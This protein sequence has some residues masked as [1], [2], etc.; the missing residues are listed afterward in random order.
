[1]IWTDA[2]KKV[3]AVA[4]DVTPEVYPKICSAKSAEYVIA[5]NAGQA[6][7]ANIQAGQALSFKLLMLS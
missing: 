6:D 4:H 2:N 3:V 1:M 5:L 7:I